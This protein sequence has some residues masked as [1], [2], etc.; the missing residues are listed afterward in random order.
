MNNFA[1]RRM[2]L[3]IMIMKDSNMN[4]EDVDHSSVAVMAAH[5]EVVFE[6]VLLEVLRVTLN[7]IRKEKKISEK[8]LEVVGV[9]E[10][11]QDFIADTFDHV[12]LASG[13]VESKM[14]KV[15]VIQEAM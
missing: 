12:V 7:M 1:V 15:V 13:P 3:V 5:P 9:D 10:A 6:V 2:M 4:R 11:D 14:M 8:L